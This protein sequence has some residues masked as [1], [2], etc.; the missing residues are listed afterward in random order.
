M[1][2]SR[3]T[4]RALLLPAL[5]A[6]VSVLACGTSLRAQGTS[7]T[8]PAATW[9]TATPESQGIDGT[10]LAQQI[11]AL[12]AP[13]NQGPLMVVA[14]GRLV[15]S[16]GDLTDPRDLFSCSKAVTAM[17]AARLA[18]QGQIPDLDD[19]VPN[20]VRGAWGSYPGDCSFRLFLNMQADYG[21]SNGRAPGTR[22]AYN[23]HGIDFVGEHLSQTYYGIGPD[24]MHDVVQ[25][26]LA[27][28]TGSEDLMSFTGQWGGWFG[29]LRA[30][31]RD[32]GRLGLLLLRDGVWNGQ[33]VL[34]AEMT[35][36]L[37]RDQMLGTTAYQSTNPNENS[38]WNQQAVTNRLADGFSW[39]VWRVG[40]TRL[41]GAWRAGTL[42]GFR[43]KRVLMC[44]RGTLANPDLE[45]MLVCL[46]NLSNEGPAT[47]LYLDALESAVIPPESHPDHDPRCLTA[48]FDD[49]TTGNLQLLFGTASPLGGE[50][51]IAA[52]SLLALPDT[53]FV[54]GT[55][56]MKIRGGLP[57]GA[58]I[59]FRIRAADNADDV[60]LATG[61]QSFLGIEHDP[62]VGLRALVIHPQSGALTWFRGPALSAVAGQDLILRVD[63]EGDRA[64][65]R[66]N[67]QHGLGAQG[68]AGIPNPPNGGRIGIRTNAHADTLHVDYVLARDATAPIAQIDVDQ[69]GDHTLAFVAPDL[70]FTLPLWTMQVLYDDVLFPIQAM[71]ILLP[72]LWPSVLAAQP[73]HV[74]LS[75]RTSAAPLQV[76][77]Q[78][79]IELA[80]QR[81]GEY[82]R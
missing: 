80:G 3:P 15:F 57:I 6:A 42:D 2:C 31:V 13:A 23:N 74:L 61:T 43:G 58:K 37:F 75:S 22:H 44:P 11:A 21:L 63:F 70:F 25:T 33:R 24:R 65:V 66:V 16:V 82:L 45:L 79:V 17:V 49:G 27:S 4:L 68:Y 5:A 62:T 10:I 78:L 18:H 36:D 76:G 51:D 9:E 26:A 54:D 47:E 56:I 35:S 71:P 72:Y 8:F 67:G 73:D 28:V 81:E 20:T 7:L 52:P 19:L 30:S 34:S 46:P 77:N 1:L 60:F 14:N 40:D 38:M 53:T 41:S 69:N 48:A 59:G 29:G 39:G 12:G 32:V 64:F 55:A 50:L